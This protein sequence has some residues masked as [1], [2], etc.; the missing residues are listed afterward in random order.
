MSVFSLVTCGERLNEGSSVDPQAPRLMQRDMNLPLPFPSLSLCW[1]IPVSQTTRC[2]TIA[3]DA[4]VSHASGWVGASWAPLSLAPPPLPRGLLCRLWKTKYASLW[5]PR[6]SWKK[7]GWK[8]I[9][10]PP[11]I[12]H[13]RKVNKFWKSNPCINSFI[14]SPKT[15]CEALYACWRYQD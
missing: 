5:R 14:H 15:L 3:F 4:L 12:P 1:G 6:K 7:I 11:W 9:V 8:N 13:L 10:R 2:N